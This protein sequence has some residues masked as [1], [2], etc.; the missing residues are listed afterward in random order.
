MNKYVIVVLLSVISFV[1]ACSAERGNL[2]RT[3]PED[4]SEEAGDQESSELPEKIRNAGGQETDF[5]RSIEYPA[6]ECPVCLEKKWL[7]EYPKHKMFACKRHDVCNGCLSSMFAHKL[8][9]NPKCPMCRSVLSSR[10]RVARKMYLDS[11]AHESGA[12][13]GTRVWQ[14]SEAG[15]VRRIA[16]A[17]EE[18]MD[19]ENDNMQYLVL[20]DIAGRVAP[21]SILRHRT[22]DGVRVLNPQE[23]DERPPF[24]VCNTVQLANFLQSGNGSGYCLTGLRQGIPHLGVLPSNLCD[25]IKL[26]KNLGIQGSQINLSNANCERSFFSDSDLRGANLSN[27]NFYGSDG[28]QANLQNANLE[29]A[30]FRKAELSGVK[31]DHANARN[32]D[33]SGADLDDASFRGSDVTGACFMGARFY[34]DDLEVVFE[35][36]IGVDLRG[37]ILSDHRTDDEETEVIE[38]DDLLFGHSFD[39]FEEV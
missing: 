27:A 32:V 23:I 3:H 11:V 34:R 8:N 21:I 19:E 10:G 16:T 33:F 7:P 39:E 31:L 9:A 15:E 28:A 2:K 38:D 35:G 26:L 22:V 12:G 29:G 25:I 5:C 13:H 18:T 17:D 37:A 4:V 14:V 36:A 24:P 20:Y 6:I 30:V 1:E